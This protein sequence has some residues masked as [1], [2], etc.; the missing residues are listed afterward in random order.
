MKILFVSIGMPNMASEQG[1]LYADLLR[2]LSYLGHDITIVAPSLPDKF[3]GLRNEDTFKVLRVPL[4]PFMGDIPFYVKGLRILQM[5]GKYLKA[6]KRYLEDEKYDI[7]MMATPPTTLVDVV[8]MVKR[9]S[10]AKFYLLLRDIHPECLKRKKVQETTLKRTDVYDE[11]KRP[12]DVNILADRLL[13][14]K[15]Q[16]LYRIADWIGCMSP[17]NQLFLKKIAPYVDD[18]KIVLLPNWYKGREYC[19]STNDDLRDKYDLKGKYIAIFGGTIGEAQA[20]WNIATLAKHN[21]DKE[22]VVFL[23]VGRGVKK[24]VLE[25]MAEQ[26]H[27]TNMRFMD[28]MPRE[29][30]ER[31]LELA[32]VGLIS[33]DEKYTV[34][35]CPSKIIGYMALAKPVIAMFNEGNDY[36]EFYIDKSGC[37]LY[38]TGLDNDKMF[39]NF[40]TLYN[41][42]KLRKDMGMNGFHY[43]KENLTAKSVAEQLNGQLEE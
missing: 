22:E 40:D 18:A 5:T 15:S 38:S 13:Y 8:K 21:L 32:D 39:K 34:P 26:D 29:D 36:G 1:G 35:T 20:V 37:G 12:Y 30:Y 16:A 41:N 31:I 28:F 7:L 33:I 9:R 27:I 4:K 42:D 2:E 3:H 23:I 6:Y 43:Y 14:R 11:C 17:G 24:K 25:N 10:G 19:N